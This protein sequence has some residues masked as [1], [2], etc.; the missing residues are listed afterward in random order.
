LR[1]RSGLASAFTLLL[2]LQGAAW[3][4]PAAEAARLDSALAAEAEAGRALD[5][6][7][8]H[9]SSSALAAAGRRLQTTSTVSTIAELRAAVEDANIGT[10][11]VAAGTYTFS[12][13]HTS[14]SCTYKAYSALCITRGVRI[15]AVGQVVLKA[16]ADGGTATRRVIELEVPAGGQA[17]LVGL[18]IS[19]GRAVRGQQPASVGGAVRMTGG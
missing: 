10:I 18:Q 7:G 5:G 17:E 2:L 14:A 3:F 6:E 19:N 13:G 15:E 16:Q 9:G 8:G 1:R 4:L 12:D 11:K